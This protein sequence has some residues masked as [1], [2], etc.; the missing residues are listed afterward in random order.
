MTDDNVNG[1]S[2]GM[3]CRLLAMQ[4]ETKLKEL[5]LMDAVRRKFLHFHRQQREAELRRLDDE[6]QRKVMMAD[7]VYT[8]A[9]AS[10]ASMVEYCLQGSWLAVFM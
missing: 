9:F 4:R 6:V 8:E 1:D 10:V 2:V 5:K 3:L 7:V